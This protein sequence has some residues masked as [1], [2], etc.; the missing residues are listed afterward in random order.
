MRKAKRCQSGKTQPKFKVIGSISPQFPA[1]LVIVGKFCIFGKHCLLCDCLDAYLVARS[2]SGLFTNERRYFRDSKMEVALLERDLTEVPLDVALSSGSSAKTLNLTEN[3]LSPPGNLQHFKAL[4]QLVLD[5]NGITTLEGYPRMETV[6]TL[7]LNKNQITDLPE[8]A[9]QILALFPN[10]TYLSAMM[11]PASPPLVLT[12]EEDVARS[13]RYRCY[14][15]YRLPRLAFLDA[16]PIT[17]DERAEGREKGDFLVARKPKRAVASGGVSTTSGS[18]A[19]AS[20]SSAGAADAASLFYGGGAAAGGAGASSASGG[21]AAADAERRKP[22][23]Y[24]GLGTTHYDGR[25]SEGNRFVTNDL[26]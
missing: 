8:L 5:N 22:A 9:D 11:N 17:A 2:A 23:A 3:R 1:P 19:A 15:A 16:S 12:S 7:W 13:R 10:L 4:E 21:A 18:G 25:H 26:L 20:G 14:M 6:T 24:L